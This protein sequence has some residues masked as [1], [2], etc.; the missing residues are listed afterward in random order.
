LVDIALDEITKGLD[1]YRLTRQFLQHSSR[2]TRE[3]F[4]GSL[5]SIAHADGEIS[6]IENEEIRNIARGLKLT[7]R[8]MIAA[9]E[10]V[11]D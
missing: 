8:Q 5:Y 2:Q 3:A 1:F 11:I 6:F 9:R 7:H 10:R 4:V